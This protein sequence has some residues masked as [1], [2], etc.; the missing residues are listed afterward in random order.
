M[1]KVRRRLSVIAALPS[2]LAGCGSGNPDS[3]V[4]KDINMNAIVDTNASAETNA[5]E[6]QYPQASNNAEAQ[7]A[8]PPKAE[9]PSAERA[10]D[11]N[12]EATQ[13]PAQDEPPAT[14]EP[15][16]SDSNSQ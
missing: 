14:D 8:V 4:G 9:R 2:L 11:N 12:A 3:M 7:V 1:I 10:S 16:A 15:P 13:Q 6:A 5:E